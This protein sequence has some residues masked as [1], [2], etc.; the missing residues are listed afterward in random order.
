MSYLIRKERQLLLVSTF[1]ALLFAIIGIA[2]GTL[3]H[4]LVIIFDGVYS[5]VSLGLTL[6]SLA[7]VLYIRQEDISKNIKRVK[8]IE[9]S[10]I[11]LKGIAITLMC[12]LSFIA[13]I[14]A[15]M[16]GG[17][18]VNTGIALAF[19]AFSMVGCYTSYWVMKTQGREVKS[20]LVDAEAK[21][22]LMDTVISAAVFVGFMAAKIL[23]LTSY[24]EYAKLADPTMVV[25]AS[26][27]FIIVPV[28]MI[29]NSTKQLHKLSRNC[30]IA[31]C[32]HV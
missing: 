3:I 26:V 30:T 22:W 2:L 13:A 18:E 31:K 12:V 20:A 14:Q 1:S 17:R 24:A 8:V 19:G 16:Q 21:Q 5:L 32:L 4:S 11:L 15:I 23:L 7:A 25:I 29:L 28:K 27:Y 9:S 10:V 6:I